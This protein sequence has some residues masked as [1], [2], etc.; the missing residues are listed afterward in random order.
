MVRF[1]HYNFSVRLSRYSLAVVI[2]SLGVLSGFVPTVVG[3][4]SVLDF[5]TS[6]WAQ[7]Q[8]ISTDEA[9]RYAATVLEM[10]PYRQEFYAKVK[11]ILGNGN[12]PEIICTERSTLQRLPQKARPIA[13]DY[14]NR[15]KKTA[16]QNNLTHTRFNDITVW[17]QSN[18]E[19]R[20]LIQNQLLL[21]QTSPKKR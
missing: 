16:T 19:I 10:E 18:E 9:R 3:K 17:A 12:V 4:S 8:T 14:C 7:T 21:L 5:N 1:L 20:T 2:A 11:Q 13:V 6:A 15:Y